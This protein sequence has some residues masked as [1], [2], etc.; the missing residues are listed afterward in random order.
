[1]NKIKNTLAQQSPK[2]ARPWKGMRNNKSMKASPNKSQRKVTLWGGNKKKG[3]G[4]GKGKK[5]KGNRW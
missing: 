2:G 5:G 3:K 4:K 1:M